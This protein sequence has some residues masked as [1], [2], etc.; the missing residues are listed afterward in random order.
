MDNG[1]QVSEDTTH[2]RLVDASYTSVPVN[3]ASH[4]PVKRPES[5][6]ISGSIYRT[7]GMLSMTPYETELEWL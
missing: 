3:I 5:D 4:L 7:V 1:F 6:L 2:K